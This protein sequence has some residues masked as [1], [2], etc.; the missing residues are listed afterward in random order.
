MSAMCSQ[1]PAV[2]A[3]GNDY[4]SFAM[5]RSASAST[6]TTPY[7]FGFNGQEHDSEIKGWQNMTHAQFWEYDPRIGKRWNLD[8]RP[9][10][11]ISEYAAFNNNPIIYS[12]P[13]GDTTYIF[14][15]K[16]ILKDIILDKRKNEAIILSNSM[17]SY[18]KNLDPK[19]YNDDAKAGLARSNAAGRFTRQ[20]QKEL[21]SKWTS[22]RKENIGFLYVDAKS[23]WIKIWTCPDCTAEP[24]PNRPT[25]KGEASLTALARHED[26]V[27]KLGT[28]LGVWHSHPENTQESSQPSQPD[29][30]VKPPTVIKSL[31]AEGV[32][33][34]VQKNTITIYPIAPQVPRIVD[35]E[36][37][38][39]YVTTPVYSEKYKKSGAVISSHQY[40]V[41]DSLL[42]PIIFWKK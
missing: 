4:Y 3:V 17:L 19:K 9:T 21:I 40:G 28:I 36:L 8:P 6:V 41:F 34:I 32:G 37:K 33:V 30:I 35:E 11:G 2:K 31:S 24:D 20:V 12:D 16:G 26:D 14:N 39:P 22:Q 29:D 38:A 10:V 23:N 1:F 42:R 18:I 25:V 15:K 13:Y 27:K 7:K 5:L